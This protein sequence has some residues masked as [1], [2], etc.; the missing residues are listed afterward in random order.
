MWLLCLRTES[1]QKGTKISFPGWEPGEGW[2][3][4]RQKSFPE[5]SV[6]YIDADALCV[7]EVGSALA[8]DVVSP[9]V[10]NAGDVAGMELD[11]L[12]ATKKGEF[13]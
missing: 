10:T 5:R 13:L 4:L 8:A 12:L 6:V 2:R 7:V 3:R 1:L 11:L 9:L